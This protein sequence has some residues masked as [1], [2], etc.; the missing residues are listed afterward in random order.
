[1]FSILIKNGSHFGGSFFVF[2]I[3]YGL[4]VLVVFLNN[5]VFIFR[6]LYKS[7]GIYM[8]FHLIMYYFNFLFIVFVARMIVMHILYKQS[9]FWG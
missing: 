9:C 1:M 2:L 3:I 4:I 5:I 7:M 8:N 6:V